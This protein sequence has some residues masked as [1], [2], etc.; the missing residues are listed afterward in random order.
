MKKESL[1]KYLFYR[2][3]EKAVY[4][5]DCELHKIIIVKEFLKLYAKPQ[6]Q[7]VNR[8]RPPFKS[9]II[10]RIKNKGGLHQ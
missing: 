5:Y 2:I 7:V 3:D 6:L 8:W 9:I 4:L 10:Y 1:T